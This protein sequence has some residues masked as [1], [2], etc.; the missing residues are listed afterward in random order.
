MKLSFFSSTFTNCLSLCDPLI[1]RFFFLLFR[2]LYF[3]YFSNSVQCYEEF[4]AKKV[5]F[6]SFLFTL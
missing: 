4:I 2:Q 5:D 1:Y 3:D 6:A